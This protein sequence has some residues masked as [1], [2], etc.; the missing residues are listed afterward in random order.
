MRPLLSL[1]TLLRAPFKTIMTF[2]LIST[3]TFAIFYRVVDF[4]VTQR[5]TKR[6][7]GYYRGVAALDNGVQN[8]ALLLASFMPN[9][10][11]YSEYDREAKSLP[12]GLTTEQ[13]EGFSSLPGVSSTDI[14]Y[15][16]AGII[17]GVDRVARWPI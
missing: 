9:T 13:I 4:T 16:T 10:V 6:I 12:K 11:R 7:T 3:A 5:E 17:E 1:K 2:L 8:T 14:R 15:M